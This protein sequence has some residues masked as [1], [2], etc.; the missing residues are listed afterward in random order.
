MRVT[1]VGMLYV[2][3]KN[4]GHEFPTGISVGFAGRPVL[5]G[6]E[7]R[8]P[9]CGVEAEYEGDDYIEHSRPP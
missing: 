2:A 9:S 4:C 1:T 6:H 3:C 5:G 8:C 7:Y